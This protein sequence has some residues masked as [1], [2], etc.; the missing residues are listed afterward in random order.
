M[1]KKARFT[2]I[3]FIFLSLLIFSQ[4]EAAEVC[5]QH[6][7]GETNTYYYV[8]SDGVSWDFTAE[9]TMQVDTIE[10]K[11]VLATSSSRTFYIQIK[12]NDTIVASWDQTVNSSTFQPFTHT[13]SVDLDLKAGDKITYFIYGGTLSSP[14]GGILGIN[15]VKL[16]QEE[17]AED[18][19]RNFVTRF[20]Q[21]CL[22]RDP[23]AAGLQG[24]TNDLLNQIKTGAD[25]AKGFIYSPEFIAKNTTN[26]EYLTILYKAFFNRDPD[27]A[28]WNT[29]LSELNS[30]KDRGEVLDGFIYSQEFSQLCQNYGIKAFDDQGTGVEAFVTRFYQLCLGRNPDPTGLQG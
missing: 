11:S 30:G 20:Y 8:Y 7:F 27:Q 21:L 13:A 2:A 6:E 10:A 4:L 1:G 14:V 15:Y 24:W 25:V 29:W 16:C 28:G 18:L 9:N 3:V 17:T 5:E 12:V 26:A 22:D 23:D 19:V